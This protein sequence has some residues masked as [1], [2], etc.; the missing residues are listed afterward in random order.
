MKNTMFPIVILAGGLA[1]RLR[2]LTEKIPKALL[3]INGKPFIHH[4]LKLLHSKGIRRVVICAGFLGEMIEEYVKEGRQYGLDVRYSF[5]GAKLLGTGGAIKRALPLLGDA[6][7]VL[8]GDSYLPCD[9]QAVQKA[10]EIN[11]KLAL[12][13]VFRNQGLWDTSN[14]EFVD[15]QILAYDKRQRTESMRYIDYGLGIFKREAFDL[16]PDNTAYDLADLYQTLLQ[17]KQL[18]GHEVQQR[19]YEGGSLAGIKEL[20]E[21]LKN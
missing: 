8:Y 16:I 13:T 19:F 14:V 3:E 10:F 18:A 7:F 17:K 11:A 1:T 20:Q 5:D 9:Y 12:M 6:F 2:P 15:G 4:Q 21:Y